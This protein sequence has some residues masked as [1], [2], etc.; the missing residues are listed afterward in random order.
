MDIEPMVDPTMYDGG[1]GFGID[2]QDVDG[3]GLL[4]VFLAQISHPVDSDYSRK[5]SDP[6]ELMINQGQA[7]GH[8]FVNRFLQKNLP[9][10][11][12]DI[13]AAAIDFDNDGRIDLSLTRDNKYESGYSKPDQKAWFGL[14]HQ[15]ADGTFES[16]GLA[17][18]I[19][20]PNAPVTPG[21]SVPRMKA[22]QNHAWSD[23]DHDGDLDLL[24]G[25]RDHGGGRANYL[26]ENQI[27]SKNTWL[28]VR[29]RGDGKRINRD[30]LGARVTIK[31]GGHVLVREVKS[32]RG[33]YDSTDT[34]VLHFGFGDL[35]ACDFTLE[36][37]WPD[38]TTKTFTGAEVPLRRYVTID[39]STGLILD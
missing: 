3:D 24:V 20:D 6:T 16:V 4:D 9:F 23:I 36:V 13:D 5:W 18:G 25:G 38:G 37:R 8:S 26:F 7:K 34:R 27:G 29:L 14:M 1:N 19:N 31:G 12:G 22:G 28:A 21:S 10:N 32:S 11:E 33:T 15:S 30:A 17:S 39:Y 35:V 2:C